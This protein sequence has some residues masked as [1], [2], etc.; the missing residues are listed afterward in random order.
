MT[1]WARHLLAKS[2][3]IDPLSI[4]EIRQFF[5]HLWN[6]TKKPFGISNNQ[7]EQFL[8]CISEAAGL[9]RQ[10]VSGALGHTFEALFSTL[11]EEFANVSPGALELKYVEGFFLLARVTE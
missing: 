3:S 1:L 6:Q 7:K 4:G 11:E 10:D 8:T 5:S 2:G 9:S